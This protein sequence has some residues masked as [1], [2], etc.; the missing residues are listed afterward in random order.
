MS[1]ITTIRKILI[2][3]TT[4]VIVSQHKTIRFNRGSALDTIIDNNE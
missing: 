1:E 2:V 3:N 4:I